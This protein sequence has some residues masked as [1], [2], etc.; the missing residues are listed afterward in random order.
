MKQSEPIYLPEDIYSQEL[1]T[2]NGIKFSRREV[3]VIACILQGKSTKKTAALLSISPK[4]VATHVRNI[5]LKLEVNSRDSIIEFFEKTESIQ[6]LKNYYKSLLI[7]IA[8]EKSLLE[9]SKL[10]KKE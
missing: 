8:F 3:D 2:I 9:I 4:T 1:Q 7:N 6:V 10:E 5:M